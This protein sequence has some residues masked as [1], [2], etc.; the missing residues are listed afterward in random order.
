MMSAIRRC[1][2]DMYLERYIRRRVGH[3]ADQACVL[4]GNEPFRNKDVK[5][6]AGDESDDRQTRVNVLWRSDQIRPAS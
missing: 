6:D 2:S 5:P 3:A 1:N 4:L